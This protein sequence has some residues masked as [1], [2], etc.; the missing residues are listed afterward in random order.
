M[1]GQIDWRARAVAHA[2]ALASM[3]AVEG[4]RPGTFGEQWLDEARETCNLDLNGTPCLC[5]R[6]HHGL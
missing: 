6:S 1:D 3:L 4:T 5:G 2:A